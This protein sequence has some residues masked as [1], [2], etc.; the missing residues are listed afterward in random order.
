MAGL[1]VKILLF[2]GCRIDL[3]LTQQ[4]FAPKT[5]RPCCVRVARRQWERLGKA[6]NEGVL[7]GLVATRI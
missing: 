3:C 5:E 1:G 6:E 7:V 4:L 2:N